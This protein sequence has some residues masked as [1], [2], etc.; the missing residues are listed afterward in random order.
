VLKAI[1]DAALAGDLHRV[2]RL[3][4]EATTRWAA[5]KPVSSAGEGDAE[6][7]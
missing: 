6:E 1:D 2:R 7:G 5:A 3:V 4:H